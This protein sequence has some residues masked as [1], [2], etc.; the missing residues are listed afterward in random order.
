MSN[1]M[2]RQLASFS[3]SV[4]RETSWILGDFIVLAAMFCVVITDQSE[5]V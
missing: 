1:R 3:V 4:V 2:V 5:L